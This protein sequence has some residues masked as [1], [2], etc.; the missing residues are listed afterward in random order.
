M[1]QIKFEKPMGLKK[2]CKYYPCH[3][4]IEDCAWCYCPLYPCK[5]KSR[6]GYWLKNPKTGKKIWACEKCVWIH[7]KDVAE[8]IL[9]E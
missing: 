5:N 7:R 9:K 3:D 6:G 4:N 8:K 1:P 2:N